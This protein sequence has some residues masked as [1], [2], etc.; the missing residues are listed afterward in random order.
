MEVTFH[1]ATRI[2]AQHAYVLSSE[3]EPGES[4]P[5]FEVQ[6][7]NQNTGE[8]MTVIA[9]LPAGQDTEDEAISILDNCINSLTRQKNKLRIQYRNSKRRKKS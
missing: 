8:V 4:T 1:G 6:F 9:F 3:M 7:C 2:T 5:S